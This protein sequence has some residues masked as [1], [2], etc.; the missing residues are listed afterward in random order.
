MIQSRVNFQ[1][2][3]NDYAAVGSLDS[4]HGTLLTFRK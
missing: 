3:S 2:G 4:V 1:T